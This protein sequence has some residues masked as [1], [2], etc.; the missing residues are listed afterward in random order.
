MANIGLDLIDMT[1]GAKPE[2]HKLEVGSTVF[3]T[4]RRHCS[5]LAYEKECIRK[6]KL[7]KMLES[8]W[9]EEEKES[10]MACRTTPY[11]KTDGDCP[12]C[13]RPT[14]GGLSQWSCETNATDPAED[15]ATRNKK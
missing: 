11:T 10:L 1:L 9:S 5:M 7:R 4:P 3:I 2:L 6:I 8:T 15:C 14:A 12:T 13:C